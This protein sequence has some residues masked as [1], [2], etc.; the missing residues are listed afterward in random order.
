MVWPPCSSW[1]E[2]PAF[3]ESLSPKKC[4]LLVSALAACDEGEFAAFHHVDCHA[5]S[6]DVCIC[7][8]VVLRPGARA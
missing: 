8:P 2:A 5:A 3:I 7:R 1:P 4:R 6:T